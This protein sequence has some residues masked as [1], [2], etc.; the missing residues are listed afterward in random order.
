MYDAQGAYVSQE[1]ADFC[2]QWAIKGIFCSP[3]HHQSNGLAE[4]AVKRFK[5]WLSR[6]TS[7]QDLALAILSWVQT[8]IAIGRPSPA[9]LHMG[10]NL[11]DD[12]N[13]QVVQYQHAWEDVRE[14]RQASKLDEAVF[15]DCKSRELKPLNV[16]D[17]V[18]ALC[19]NEWRMG[20]IVALAERPRAYVVRLHNTG[21]T[22]ERNRTFLRL[23]LTGKTK[24]ASN[25][26][27]QSLFLPGVSSGGQNEDPPSVLVLPD[28]QSTS[29]RTQAAS[30][31]STTTPSTSGSSP[32]SSVAAPQ[33][34]PSPS[35]RSVPSSALPN[36]RATSTQQS[37]SDAWD[38]ARA[39]L[40]SDRSTR[41]GRSVQLPRK[42]R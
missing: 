8:P 40:E 14:W 30:R 19:R 31:S 21:R 1:F 5:K 13:A 25:M 23:N 36:P 15:F 6:S 28:D 17:E 11:R 2:A 32:S 34:S 26:Y 22:L 35:S 4:S 33:L 12:L 7:D 39:F 10:R 18:F 20:R 27:A 9:Q 42:Y 16:G 37:R 29:R 41:V 3:E 38:L 24:V